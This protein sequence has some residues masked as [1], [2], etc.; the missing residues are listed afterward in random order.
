MLE[1]HTYTHTH[2]IA[3]ARVVAVRF[4]SVP[5]VVEL[6]RVSAPAF[7]PVLSG[8]KSGTLAKA[9]LVANLNTQQEQEE[10]S[11]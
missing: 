6:N 4:H 8:H 2:L 7:D 9:V 3:R 5:L 11:T 10:T 1:T